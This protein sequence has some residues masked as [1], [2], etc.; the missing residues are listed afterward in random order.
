MWVTVYTDASWKHG[1]AGWAVWCRSILGRIVATGFLECVSNMEAETVAVRHAIKIV[2]TQWPSVHGIQVNTDCLE[3]EQII[4]PELSQLLSGRHIR[5]KH[6]K[7]HH[8]TGTTRS[9][10][11]MRVDSLA[12]QARKNQR[13][14]FS[15]GTAGSLAKGKG[16]STTA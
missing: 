4:Q 12:K 16:K 15:I 9:W 8:N 6:V 11:N 10:I 13:S 5:F 3:V 7:G 2:L 1:K 14:S